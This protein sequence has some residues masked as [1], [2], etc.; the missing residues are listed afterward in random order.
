MYAQIYLMSEI[1]CFYPMCII[2]AS[3]AFVITTM[4]SDLVDTSSRTGL[5]YSCM[6]NITIVLNFLG[7]AGNFFVVP[8]YYDFSKNSCLQVFSVI[9]RGSY[10]F[11][12][13]SV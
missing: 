11:N 12:N 8:P 1:T 7:K 5:Y 4:K 10:M 6:P 13:F 2:T 3:P 9:R